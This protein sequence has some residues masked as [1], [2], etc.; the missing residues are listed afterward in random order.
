MSH[1]ASGFQSSI[2]NEKNSSVYNNLDIVSMFKKI[3][4]FAYKK[5]IDHV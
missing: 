5:K 1:W 4:F 2:F 3:R